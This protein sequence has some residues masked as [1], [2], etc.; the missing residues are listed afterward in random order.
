MLEA[1]FTRLLIT[2]MVLLGKEHNVVD[3]EIVDR[4]DLVVA[5]VLNELHPVQRVLPVLL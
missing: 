4:V 2:L 1:L 3:V 5:P